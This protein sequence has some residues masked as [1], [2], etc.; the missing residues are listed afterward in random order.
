MHM[1]CL[2]DFQ[3]LPDA[4]NPTPQELR[5]F[6][7]NSYDFPLDVSTIVG[8][9]NLIGFAESEQAQRYVFKV[10]SREESTQRIDAEAKVIDYLHKKY[11]D[12]F[13]AILP[14]VNGDL[15]E[16]CIIQE[17]DYY[18]WVME[19]RDG[20]ALGA[21]RDL[22][23]ELLFDLGDKIGMLAFELAQV[24]PLPFRHHSNWAPHCAADRVRANLHKL[25][26]TTQPLVEQVLER[27]RTRI[28]PIASNLPRAV[29]HNDL[30]DGNILIDRR[31][32]SAI[33]DFGDMIETYR[34][35]ELANAFAYMIMGRKSIVGVISGVVS[36]Y[37]QHVKLSEQE[38]DVMMDFVLLRLALSLT[39][40]HVQHEQNPE[41]LRLVSSQAAVTQ[42][43]NHLLANPDIIEACRRASIK[44]V[45]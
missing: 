3:D 13:P 26:I 25:P 28:Q 6:L 37:L 32:V 2:T 10:F 34:I 35:C 11:P 20:I 31:R 22:P 30:N 33:I 38:L 40:S 29:I 21:T 4:P 8:E 44:H 17:K 15:T 12:A 14:S 9:R 27:H 36:T 7:T 1:A 16:F 43:L 41:N 5:K 39:L 23:N 42:L 18:G 45:Q 19:F 24:D